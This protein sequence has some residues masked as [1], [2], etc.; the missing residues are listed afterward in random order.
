MWV[1]VGKG[2]DLPPGTR[3]RI[4]YRVE[5]PEWLGWAPSQAMDW[6]MSGMLTVWAEVQRLYSSDAYW[7]RYEIQVVDPGKVYVLW[8]YGIAKGLPVWIVAIAILS[9]IVAVLWLFNITLQ[10]VEKWSWALMVL[11]VGAGVA[12]AGYGVYKI[13]SAVRGR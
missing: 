8:M 11:F 2:E 5:V 9:L 4:A 3:F 1:P 7:E 13:T 6:I 10:R 12:L